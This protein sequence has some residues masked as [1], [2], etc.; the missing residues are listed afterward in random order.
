[1]P[2]GPEILIS[3]QYLLS[4]LKNRYIAGAKILS[5]KYKKRDLP[6][7]KLLKN[8]YKIK[9]IYSKGKFM[10][11]TL[12]GDEKTDN[13]TIYLLSTFGMTGRW[14]F[15]KGDHSRVQFDIDNGDKNDK[16]YKLYFSDMRN[17]GNMSITDDKKVLEKKIDSLGIDLIRSDLSEK[18]MK[19]HINEFIK[20]R[21]EGKRKRNNNIVTI[22][23][24][25][26]VNKGI[27]SGIGNYLCAEILYKAKISPHRDITDL[28]SREVTSLV[29]AIRSK[30]KAAYVHNAT[31]Y[32]LK[33][34]KFMGS[35]CK[36]IKE[37]KFPNYYKDIKLVDKKFVFEVYG[38]KKDPLGNEVIGENIHAERTTWWV[39]AVQK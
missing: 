26:E 33:L 7:F 11:M 35:H 25:Q 39:K 27:G 5:G 22:L 21:R 16:K 19:D 3:S 17:F 23:M 30:M 28:K 4:K 14:E 32:L 38:Q 6:G 15:K 13:Q 10:W 34:E 8:R 1:M 37:G 36:K 18:E 9:D 12:R 24:T 31:H 20:K 29:K 2:E